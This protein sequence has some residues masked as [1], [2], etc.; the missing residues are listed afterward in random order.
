MILQEAPA[1]TIS[2]MIPGYV[3]IFGVMGLTW[4]A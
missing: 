1:E 3:V 2:Y 4:P